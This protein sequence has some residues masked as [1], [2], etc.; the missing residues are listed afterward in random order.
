MTLLPQYEIKRGGLLITGL[1]ILNQD[2]TQ[3]I[4][5]DGKNLITHRVNQFFI[6]TL[7]GN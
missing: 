1:G 2:V 6:L 4:E 3:D 7:N 5:I